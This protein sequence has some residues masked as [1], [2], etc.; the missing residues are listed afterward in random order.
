MDKSRAH[1]V[2]KDPKTHKSPLIKTTI[3][4][5]IQK[6]KVDSEKRHK[7]CMQELETRRLDFKIFLSG[8]SL[9]EEVLEKFF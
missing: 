9:E 1:W 8:K 5:D 2:V 4:M 3:P 6:L 7:L